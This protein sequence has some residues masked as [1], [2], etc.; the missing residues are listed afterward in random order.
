MRIKHI[1]LF[2]CFTLLFASAIYSQKQRT[3]VCI[4]FRMNSIVIDTTYMDNAA[5]IHELNDFLRNIRQDTTVQVL[6]VSF[7]GVASPEDSYQR[8]R[9][10]ARGRINV[11]EKLVR[12]TIIFPDSIVFRDD[13]YIPW[14]MLKTKVANSQLKYKE[15]ILA[16][17][18]EDSVL[19]NYHRTGEKVDRRFVRI[20]QID[21]GRTWSQMNNLFFKDLRHACV[22][23]LIYKKEPP[24]PVIEPKP[25]P[26]IIEK[27]PVEEVP[28]TVQLTDTIPIPPK[29]NFRNFHLKSNL[30]GLGMGVANVAFEIDMAKHWSFSLPVYYSAWNY[31][32]STIKFRT[33]AVQPEFRYW[34]SRKNNGFFAGGHFGMAF[35][36]LAVNGDYRYQDHR[37]ETPALGGGVSVGYRLPM[38]KNK[39]WQ[40]EFVVGAGA[41]KLHY[42]KFY[43]NSHTTQ[44]LIAGSDRKT[45]WGV[46]Q[47]AISFTY[48]FHLGKEGGSR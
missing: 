20:K 34:P 32:T 24:K 18:E 12:N 22:E 37:R 16:I 30:L 43:N 41:Y 4:D 48:A 28:D 7:K 9:K 40:V 21:D 47:A 13:R 6:A 15:E 3:E 17:L 38:S 1:I 46:D 25:E 2:L 11:V 31:F 10:L 26:E 36:N 14:S 35:Y 45:Y 19:V 23:L 5:R 44:G 33:F 42:D 27:E 8:N 29:E 39:R